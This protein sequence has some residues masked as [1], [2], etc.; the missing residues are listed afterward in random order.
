MDAQKTP[1]KEQ[2]GVFIHN[3][4]H[5][6]FRNDVLTVSSFPTNLKNLWCRKCVRR[7]IFQNVEVRVT[8]FA[9][10]PLDHCAT[11]KVSSYSKNE[12]KLFYQKLDAE[13]F[14]MLQF[15]L[16][17][18]IFRENCK[19]LFWRHIWQFFRRRKRLA[20][21]INVLNFFLSQMSYWIFY[22][23]AVFLKKKTVIFWENSKKL[24]LGPK[25]LLKGRKYLATK[26]NITFFLWEIIFWIF[27]HLTIFSKK[28]T[29]LEKMGRKI[30]RH[31]HF[32]EGV[33]LR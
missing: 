16:K 12:Y 27:F 29:F 26:M 23:S 14:F 31:D 10:W 32:L 2:G 11:C 1:H 18:N 6:I 15:F 8:S 20:P 19:E 28:A 13:Y 22:Y 30:W 24:F 25:S 9:T 21:K 7:A 4:G 33:I 3:D 17:S 5:T